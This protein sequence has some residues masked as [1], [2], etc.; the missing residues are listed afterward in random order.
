MAILKR[1]SDGK[2]DQGS[3]VEAIKWDKVK[4]TTEVVG[5]KPIIGCA[6]LVGSVTA[7]SYSTKKNHS[8]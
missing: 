1:V 3:R 5:H 8:G 4:G 6:L 2:G 7:R